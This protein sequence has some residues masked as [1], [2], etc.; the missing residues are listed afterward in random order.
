MAEQDEPRRVDLGEG[1][2]EVRELG[3]EVEHLAGAAFA[4]AEAAALEAQR[5]EAEPREL[6]EQRSDGRDGRPGEVDRR[7]RDA[8][9]EHDDW[10]RSR[11]G[12]DRGD[13]AEP[14]ATAGD[15]AVL[16]AASVEALFADSNRRDGR[17]A[18]GSGAGV[19]DHDVGPVGAE[20]RSERR[21][22]G[23]GRAGDRRHHVAWQ[24]PGGGGHGPGH[25]RG[26]D[27]PAVAKRILPQLDAQPKTPRERYPRLMEHALHLYH[28]SVDLL[29]TEVR[30]RAPHRRIVALDTPE[31][32]AAALPEITVLCAPVPPREGW[33][34]AQKL[35]LIQLLGVGADMLLPSLDLPRAVEVATLRGVFAAEVTEHVVAMMLALVRAVPTLVARQHVREWVQFGSGTLAGKTI[36][37]VGL[38]AIGSRIARAATALDMRV[39]ATRRT[40]GASV[41]HVERVYASGD[42]DEMLRE[43]D[44]VV[45]CVPKTVETTRLFDRTR[46]LGMKPGAIL[47]NVARGGIVDEGALLE[48]LSSGHLGGAAMDVFGEEPLPPSNPLWTA[49][50]TIVTPHIAGWGLDY[51]GRGVEVLLENVSRLEA[52]APRV[53]LVDREVGY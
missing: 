52:N 38:G 23:H 24:N 5:R 29:V 42:L 34:H 18:R 10:V 32:L 7:A 4:V 22:V 41:R 48:A 2:A 16:D 12:G 27:E 40:L 30:K 39:L 20:R 37:L 35:R 33:S 47:V 11:A 9:E 44:F 13:R 3:L 45:V 19:L 43:S 21:S 31:A 26:R 15:R 6:V 8:L 50:N 1:G 36:G 49:P 17:A 53:G 14:H 25:H 28:Q 51:V 46:F